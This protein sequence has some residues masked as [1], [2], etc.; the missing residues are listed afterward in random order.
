MSSPRISIRTSFLLLIDLIPLRGRL[1]D[2]I[3]DGQASSVRPP[4]SGLQTRFLYAASPAFFRFR[5]AGAQALL[6]S[7][8]IL[9]S[10]RFLAS[11]SANRTML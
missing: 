3:E 8:M 2:L 4:S 9:A 7:S 10:N 6:Y 11:S 1:I 5:G